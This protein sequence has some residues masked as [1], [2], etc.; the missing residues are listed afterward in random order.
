MERQ[1]STLFLLSS[2]VLWRPHHSA[3]ISPRPSLCCWKL[4]AMGGYKI[5]SGSL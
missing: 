3:S 2:R 4:V 1:R 5:S